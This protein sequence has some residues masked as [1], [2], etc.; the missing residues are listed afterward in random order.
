MGLSTCHISPLVYGPYETGRA[1]MQHL[2]VP[3]ARYWAEVAEQGSYLAVRSTGVRPCTKPNTTQRG[4]VKQFTPRSRSRMLKHFAKI[5]RSV[6]SESLL[7]T[8]TYPRLFPTESSTY[9]RH[10]D[11]FSKRLLR[12]FPRSCATWKLEFQTRGAPHFH[13]IVTGV[14]FLSRRWLSRAWYE[15]AGDGDERNLRAGTQVVRADSPRKALSYAA[16]YCA[17]IS[18]GATG[19]H[20]GRFWG[21]VGRAN[22]NTCVNQWPLDRRGH[23]RLSRVIRGLVSSRP[24]VTARHRYTPGW[25]FAT[26]EAGVRAILYAG[27][28]RWD[29][30]NAKGPPTPIPAKRGLTVTT[31]VW[32]QEIGSNNYRAVVATQTH[33]QSVRHVKHNQRHGQARI[34]R[35]GGRGGD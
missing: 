35:C 1:R 29:S 30:V 32:W 31:S 16:K 4:T 10:L 8:L 22:L 34:G 21:V 9:K 12:T 27:G 14:S 23:A 17:K 7:V 19:E 28:E 25:C 5:D 33:G 18:T 26:G 20:S 2:D 24:S 3:G 13:L 11:S 6:L 15:I